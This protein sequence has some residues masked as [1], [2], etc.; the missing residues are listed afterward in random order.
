MFSHKKKGH[1]RQQ[2][3]LCRNE[4]EVKADIPLVGCLANDTENLFTAGI[5]NSSEEIRK[6]TGITGTAGACVCPFACLSLFFL[7]ER[8][9]KARKT[10][11]ER[12]LAFQLI[13]TFLPTNM[14]DSESQVWVNS[15]KTR[16]E[17]VNRRVVE[18][19]MESM[20]DVWK[21]TEDMQ[22]EWWRTRCREDK[23]IFSFSWQLTLLTASEEMVQHFGEMHSLDFLSSQTRRLISLSCL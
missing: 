17:E 4:L 14:R 2:E 15:E 21:R 11:W 19:M 8:K 9:K 6:V 20:V 10:E 3:K 13:N 23:L 7:H 5:E 1:A 22:E 12:E 18:E 16:P